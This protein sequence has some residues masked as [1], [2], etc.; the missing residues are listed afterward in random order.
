MPPVDL[1]YCASKPPVFTWTSFTKL[2]LMPV[3]SEPYTRE[4]TPMPPNPPSVMLTP[5]ASE[6]DINLPSHFARLGLSYSSVAD[7]HLVGFGGSR[8]E[9]SVMNCDRAPKFRCRGKVQNFHGFRRIWLW[10]NHQLIAGA[11]ATARRET[12]PTRPRGSGI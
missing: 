10:A 5:S 8:P 12:S 4:Y 3:E 9:V 7:P 2:R 6:S 1:P 11:A